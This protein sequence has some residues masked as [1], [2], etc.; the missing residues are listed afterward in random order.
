L[1]NQSTQYAGQLKLLE[2]NNVKVLAAATASV[3]TAYNLISTKSGELQQLFAQRKSL[4]AESEGVQKKQ[5]SALLSIHSTAMGLQKRVESVKNEVL[6]LQSKRS[7]LLKAI[8]ERVAN[9]SN[10]IYLKQKEIDASNTAYSMAL[11]DSIKFENIRD[12][13]QIQ[14]KSQMEHQDSILVVIRSQIQNSSVE[15]EQARSDSSKAVK[16]ASSV[17]YPHSKKI[18]RVDS[19]IFIKEKELS[20]LRTARMQAVEDSAAEATGAHAKILQAQAGVRQKIDATAAL[21]IQSVAQEKEKKRIEAEAVTKD[22]QFKNSRSAYA[23]TLSR[24]RE[25]ITNKKQT[26]QQLQVELSAAENK[27]LTVQGKK[28]ASASP[29]PL[30]SSINS[31]SAAQTMIEKIYSL[32]GENRM[33]EARSLFISNKSQLQTYALLEAFQMLEASF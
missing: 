3:K 29:P 23:F 13:A 15:L 22:Q 21:E 10:S 2:S 20:V 8:Q 17:M 5:N 4:V 16:M 7:Y 30:K 6:S 9:I 28:I 12:I 33:T 31:S 26:I 18:H 27:F 24:N 19:M 32:I 25:Q 1:S 14:I 11:Q